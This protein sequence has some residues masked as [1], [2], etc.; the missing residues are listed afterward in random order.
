MTATGAANQAACAACSFFLRRRSKAPRPAA[1]VANSQTA[2]GIGV[3]PGTS[4]GVIPGEQQSTTPVLPFVPLI[5]SSAKY[6]GRSPG[7]IVDNSLKLANDRPPAADS[8]KVSG[9]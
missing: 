1:P 2:P 8:V 5:M 6:D 4:N 3:S 7:G 9:P